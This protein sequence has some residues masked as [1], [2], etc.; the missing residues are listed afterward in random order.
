MERDEK[1]KEPQAGGR[2]DETLG[3]WRK[4]FLGRGRNWY[5]ANK[6]T[7]KKLNLYFLCNHSH[8]IFPLIAHSNMKLLI[9]FETNSMSYCMNVCY[10]IE[11]LPYNHT[12][13]PFI[14]FFFLLPSQN[15]EV[16]FLL[17]VP[18]VF[19]NMKTTATFRPRFKCSS[20]VCFSFV[21]PFFYDSHLTIN[22]TNYHLLSFVVTV[23]SRV[24]KRSSSTKDDQIYL[25]KKTHTYIWGF[26][27]FLW[28]SIFHFLAF[29]VEQ[30]CYYFFIVK[31]TE[32]L[33]L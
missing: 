25:K 19:L 29:R 27:Y 6:Q 2:W 24:V 8:I 33:N 7:K 1:G 23:F 17:F 16:Y 15:V 30:V 18:T 31:W 14:I 4:F 10:F 28:M 20:V 9:S 12:N 22:G 3:R 21:S 32:K 5:P 13:S 11:S 26:F